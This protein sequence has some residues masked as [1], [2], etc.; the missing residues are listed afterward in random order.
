MSPAAVD[1]FA[2][3]PLATNFSVLPLRSQ[4]LLTVLVTMTTIDSS[5][6]FMLCA[7]AMTFFGARL[8]ARWASEQRRLVVEWNM[9]SFASRRLKSAAEMSASAVQL[10]AKRKLTVGALV[11]A[12]LTVGS[13]FLSCVAVVELPWVVVAVGVQVAN[14][15]ILAAGRELT[16][17]EGHEDMA[18][19]DGALVLRVLLPQ[20][21][22]SYGGLLYVAFGKSSPSLKR[23][24]GVWTWT[25]SWNLLSRVC[26]LKRSLFYVLDR[27]GLAGDPAHDCPPVRLEYSFG[28]T[29]LEPSCV[30]ELAAGL[31]WI[32]GLHVARWVGLELALPLFRKVV[33]DARPKAAAAAG[34]RLQVVVEAAKPTADRVLFAG[35]DNLA[36]QFGW[37]GMFG[38]VRAA[39]HHQRRPTWVG[40]C[41]RKPL[42]L[43]SRPDCRH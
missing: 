10:T 15:L 13:A 27:T 30:A 40:H 12:V 9:E 29:E 28:H 21:A 33:Q 2:D 8:P 20:C 38:A 5:P 19:F 43:P 25:L 6:T 34:P 24:L 18:A 36:L 22:A 3:Q 14:S 31:P 17:W 4:V 41:R 16:R 1:G 39:R 35:Y 42:R 7:G 23:A 37:V 26:H 11:T 32:L